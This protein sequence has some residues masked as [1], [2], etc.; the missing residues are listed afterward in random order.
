MIFGQRTVEHGD[1]FHVLHNS[2][3]SYS[4]TS[5]KV[6]SAMVIRTNFCNKYFYELSNDANACKIKYSCSLCTNLHTLPESNFV[7]K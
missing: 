7:V 2:F 3:V 4:N 1:K 5:N 6:I